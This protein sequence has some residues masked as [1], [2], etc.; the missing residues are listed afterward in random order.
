[1]NERRRALSRRL[2]RWRGLIANRV[3]GL[4]I[5][6]LQRLDARGCVTEPPVLSRPGCAKERVV[7]TSFR[8]RSASVSTR[9]DM[10]RESASTPS[11]QGTED[12]PQRSDGGP[13]PLP[14]RLVRRRR[15]ER[16]ERGIEIA[17]QARLTGHV[18]VDEDGPKR[19]QLAAV[20]RRGCEG[21]HSSRGTDD[22]YDRDGVALAVRP[23]PDAAYVYLLTECPI[24]SPRPHGR[25]TRIV[26]R[27]IPWPFERGEQEVS[28]TADCAAPRTQQV[29]TLLV[30]SADGRRL[31]CAL[32]ATCPSMSECS[33]ARSA[34]CSSSSTGARWRG[35]DVRVAAT[36]L[37]GVATRMKKAEKS[38]PTRA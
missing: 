10:M 14:A 18:A 3:L 24:V 30:A 36:S 4:P 23:L 27:H 29:L 6:R 35:R 17:P 13:A 1:M 38:T 32:D 7:G 20:G 37:S 19:R 21:M 15:C 28:G 16:S 22:A 26:V 5:H 12:A 9:S 31:L 2:Q 33:A 11:E 34:V 8:L 25:V